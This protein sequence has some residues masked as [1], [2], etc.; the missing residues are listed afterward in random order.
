MRLDHMIVTHGDFGEGCVTVLAPKRFGVNSE[1]LSLH[2]LCSERLIA[3]VALVRLL[4]WKEI[5]FKNLTQENIPVGSEPSACQPY[6]LHTEQV[7]RYLLVMVTLHTQTGRMKTLPSRKQPFLKKI[8]NKIKFEKIFFTPLWLYDSKFKSKF[9]IW[10][11]N[12][13]WKVR[14]HQHY[15]IIK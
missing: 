14:L 9:N 11:K 5:P 15:C 10:K 4:S 12:Q 2:R 8:K 3:E 7:L 13:H 6:V 1:M